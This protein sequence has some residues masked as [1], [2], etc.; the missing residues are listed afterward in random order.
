[1]PVDRSVRRTIWVDD[2]TKDEAEELLKLHGHM[3][4]TD[5]FLDACSLAA[6]FVLSCRKT[7]PALSGQPLAVL[8]GGYRRAGS[9]A[10]L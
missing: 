9:G 6:L 3:D 7:H 10:H 2:L 4:K 8:S 5:E 1:M